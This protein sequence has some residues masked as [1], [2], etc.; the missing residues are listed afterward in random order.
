MARH[1]LINQRYQK[2]ASGIR[3]LHRLALKGSDESPEAEAI[4]DSLDDIWEVLSQE[5]R[6]RAAGLS[7]DL[8]SISEPESVGSR[9]MNPQ[10]Q[11]RFNDALEAR[12][13][14]D[15]DTA[16]SLLRRWGKHVDTA[17]LSYL[18]GSIWLE[19]GDPETAVLFFENASRLEPENGRYLGCWLQT[20]NLVDPAAAR[21]SAHKLLASHEALAPVAFAYAATI[22][23]SEVQSLPDTDVPRLARKLVVVLEASLARIESTESAD[24]DRHAAGMILALLGVCHELLNETSAALESYSR[25]LQFDPLNDSLL[26]L[27]G[28]LL[29]GSTELAI[30]D[31]QVAIEYD[32]SVALPYYFLAHDSLSA[33]RFE[34][35]RIMC[36]RA[37]KLRC[38]AA[39]QSE[40]AEWLAI[41]QAELGFPASS[42]RAS[43]ELAIHR[44]PT[45]DRA[46]RNLR[47]FESTIRPFAENQW[48]TRAKAD[49]RQAG[50][51]EWRCSIAA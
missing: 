8:Y 38:S 46:R 45:N 12:Q 23:L 49:I 42:V 30:K 28:M 19:A 18:R 5:E 44:D 33:R 21:E 3:A 29:Y 32:S 43:F 4:R 37:I 14:G 27:R 40:L 24:L 35:C 48:V 11:S 13:R 39:M 1:P 31:F 22:A 47:V 50:Q 25:G 15:W 17:L 16:L 6:Q 34:D 10:A 2:L 51:I 7:E 9:E 36:E 20:Q 26:I 41:A